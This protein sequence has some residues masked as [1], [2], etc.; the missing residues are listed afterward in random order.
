M[1]LHISRTVAA[2][3]LNRAYATAS[4]GIHDHHWT[5]RIDEVWAF[6]SKTYVPALGTILLAK[7]VDDRVDVGTIKVLPDDVNPRTFSLRTLC[8]SVLVPGSKRLQFSIRSTGRE[9]LNNQPW[10]RFSHVDEINRVR[11]PRD[12]ERYR[13]I[14][15][16]IDR[17]DRVGA[18]LALTS[19]VFVGI[20]EMGKRQLIAQVAGS[21]SVDA[22][23]DGVAELMQY[24]GPFVVQALGAVFVSQ[25]AP[26]IATRRLN[27]PSRD[28]PGD[29]QA[30]DDQGR[31]FL[32]LEARN[33]RV[34]MSDALAFA[35]ACAAHGISR[36]IILELTGTATDLDTRRVIAECWQQFGVSV[37]VI[38][39]MT[40]YV[41]AAAVFG[42]NDPGE[43]LGDFAGALS[44]YLDEIEA[45]EATRGKWAEIVSQRV[46]E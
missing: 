32:S 7:T 42:L 37:S 8:H 19:Y 10:F 22:I 35:G 18:Q 23:L 6:A 40:A 30:L 46:F 39:S 25:F 24:G 29:V 28:F 5:Q 33:K 26:Q 20:R 44:F 3:R 16:E 17:L 1:P 34:S 41:T 43:F 14:L 11:D 13:Q 38:D 45:P 12:L 4:A 21:L 36:G 2:E 15:Q 27:D 31:P 9:P